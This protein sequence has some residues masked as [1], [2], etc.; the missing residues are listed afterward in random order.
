MIINRISIH[1]FLIFDYFHK[2]AEA[3]Q[4]LVQAWKDGKIEVDDATET[5]VPAKFEEIPAV[6]MRLFDGRNT[7]KLTTELVQ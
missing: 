2:I 4:I 1:G 5:V 6:W 3:R 7:G